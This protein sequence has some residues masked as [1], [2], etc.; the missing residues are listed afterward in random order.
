MRLEVNV[1]STGPSGATIAV[2][3]LLVGVAC[4]GVVWV[5]YVMKRS[6]RGVLAIARLRGRATS[7]PEVHYLKTDVEDE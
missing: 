3:V 6:A 7:D 4:V 5:A 1:S 2:T